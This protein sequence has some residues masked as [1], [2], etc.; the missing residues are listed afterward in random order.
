MSRKSKDMVFCGRFSNESYTGIV[1]VVQKHHI[2][3]HALET[4]LDFIFEATSINV[5]ED[6]MGKLKVNK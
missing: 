1:P 3:G 5:N 6:F 4:M 2:T